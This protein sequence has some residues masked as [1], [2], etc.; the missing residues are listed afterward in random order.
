MAYTI[1]TYI[2][3]F[4]TAYSG[5]LTEAKS[6]GLIFDDIKAFIETSKDAGVISEPQSF[7]SKLQ[8]MTAFQNQLIASAQN[9][10]LQLVDKKFKFDKELAMLDAQISKI[11]SDKAL[12]DAQKDGITQQVIDNR[13]I[14]ALNSLANTY[15]T[16]GAGGLTLSSDMWETYFN[17]ISSLISNLNDYKG[18]WNAN[19]NTPDISAITDMKEGD[20]YRV[21]IAGSTNLDGT[22]IWTVGDIVVYNKEIW[23]KS[24]VMLPGN[25]TVSRV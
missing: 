5:I 22:D 9:V 17:L 14:K 8:V 23:E 16:F 1:E 19:T 18:E 24:T 3:E 11:N 15:G 6:T 10:A 7:Q 12:V 13:K 2:T 21:S 20:F 4:N 25:T